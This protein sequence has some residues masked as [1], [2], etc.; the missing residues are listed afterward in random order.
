MDSSFILGLLIAVGNGLVCLLLPV[1][2][3]WTQQRSQANQLS[4]N[5]LETE[6]NQI[7]EK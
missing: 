1:A 5:H 6:I 7:V 4:F 3:S 2:L